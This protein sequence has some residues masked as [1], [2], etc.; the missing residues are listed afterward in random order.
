MQRDALFSVAWFPTRCFADL[1]H[2]RTV[3]AWTE[4]VELAQLARKIL[5]SLT[6]PYPVVHAV[7]PSATKWLPS[8]A[9]VKL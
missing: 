5:Q 3:L 9:A 2:T 4:M 7:K 6:G 1:P 8:S